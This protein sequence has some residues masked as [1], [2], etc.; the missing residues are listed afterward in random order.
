MATLTNSAMDVAEAQLENAGLTGFFERI[1]SADTVGRLKPAL[2]PYQHAA[3]ELEVPVSSLRL[4]AAHGWDVAGALR[5]GCKGA[6]VARPGKGLD[7]LSPSPDVVGKDVL[8]VAQKLL[9]R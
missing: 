7:P 3:T 1:L 8:E 4:V 2:E 9:A 5:A 6:F